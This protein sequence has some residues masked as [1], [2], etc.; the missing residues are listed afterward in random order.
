MTAGPVLVKFDLSRE[1]LK[2][3]AELAQVA[4][5]ECACRVSLVVGAARPGSL[6]ADAGAAIRP[7]TEYAAIKVPAL[8]GTEIW[9][10]AKSLQAKLER[11]VGFDKPSSPLLVFAAD[12][13]LGLKATNP[14]TEGDRPLIAETAVPLD[15][16]TG[17]VL[18]DNVSGSGKLS[19]ADDTVVARL[20]E[21]GH[22]V[23]QQ[24]EP[25]A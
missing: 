11:A 12:R 20:R 10:V 16:G 18:V 14:V 25:S 23:I 13:L 3:F 6:S 22:L 7:G 1:S 5:R 21:S 24:Q 8:E 19:G 9:I 15:S 17:A 2:G 4:S